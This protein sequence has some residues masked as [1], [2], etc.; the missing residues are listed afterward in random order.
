M[1]KL[2]EQ[3]QSTSLLELNAGGVMNAVHSI[4]NIVSVSIHVTMGNVTWLR[5]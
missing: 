3:S 5:A 1:M 4:L 2:N